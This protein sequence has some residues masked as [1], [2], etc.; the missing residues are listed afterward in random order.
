MPM[1]AAEQVLIRIRIWFLEPGTSRVRW[2]R[3]SAAITAL[4]LV[5]SLVFW[6]A[7]VGD[8][9]ADT[10]DCGQT[11]GLLHDVMPK[12][13]PAHFDQLANPC[14]ELDAVMDWVFEFV[15]DNQ[16]RGRLFV[17]RVAGI[18]ARIQ[19][20]SEVARCGY[21]TDHLAVV[22]FRDPNRWWSAGV[23]VAV[24]GGTFDALVETSECFLMHQV[25]P[26]VAARPAPVAPPAFT[27][28]TADQPTT[29]AT[30]TAWP[31]MEQTTL[32]ADTRQWELNG[33]GYT[34]IWI[35]SS[36]DL[37]LQLGAARLP[38]VNVSPSADSSATPLPE[39]P[40]THPIGV[41][42]ED[43]LALRT[44]PGTW[45]DEVS[46][47]DLPK[48]WASRGYCYT[49]GQPV[50]DARFG[51]SP[52]WILTEH[53]FY[54]FV[55]HTYFDTGGDITRQMRHCTER[56]IASHTPEVVT[57]TVTVD[58]AR[59]RLAPTRESAPIAVL[60][61]GSRVEVIC[62]THGDIVSD[63]VTSDLWVMVYL[64]KGSPGFIWRPYL[65]TGGDVTAQVL[66]CP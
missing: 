24:R 47:S 42:L 19:A 58:R 17:R 26:F 43:N 46:T 50:T 27:T 23:V 59:L 54:G 16:S 11:G 21:R 18:L 4:M 38:A 2:R 35:G 12:L 31:G 29:A 62:Y 49:E 33:D 66:A 6:A 14:L 34:L 39:R 5:A 13:D 7:G 25:I 60:A 15:P 48:G 1:N 37:C 10:S 41:V 53:I 56:E 36:D 64:D 3:V 45:F 20:L 57:G 30:P 32:C 44:G 52:Y 63:A 8:T 28:S 22:A 65:D 55:T 9:T 61:D 40:N 51:T